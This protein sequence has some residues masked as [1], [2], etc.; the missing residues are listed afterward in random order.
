[1]KKE[2]S[3]LDQLAS[4]FESYTEIIADENLLGCDAEAAG[5][6]DTC[7]HQMMVMA[8]LKAERA[9]VYEQMKQEPE[10]TWSHMRI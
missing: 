7:A 6:S 8:N 3:K 1:M 2:K 5:D 9:E 10:F 4:L